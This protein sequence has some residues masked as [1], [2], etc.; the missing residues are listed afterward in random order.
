MYC[1]LTV[2]NIYSVVPD[3]FFTTTTDKA[4]DAS[5]HDVKQATSRLAAVMYAGCVAREQY[6]CIVPP[7]IFSFL[8][9]PDLMGQRALNLAAQRG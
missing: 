7:S 1:P 9:Y 8:L 3:L 5:S 2:I 4:G 6:G